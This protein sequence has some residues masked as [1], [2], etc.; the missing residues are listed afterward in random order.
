MQIGDVSDRENL[1]V[2]VSA[3]L[4][5]AIDPRIQRAHGTREAPGA[6]I[7]RGIA[8]E[9][10]RRHAFVRQVEDA[11]AGE[12]QHDVEEALSAVQEFG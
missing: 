8:R 3:S 12:R 6:E 11:L 7:A 4:L 2:A 5:D 9:S 10:F 1:A